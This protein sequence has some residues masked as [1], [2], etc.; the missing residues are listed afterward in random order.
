MKV[1]KCRRGMRGVEEWKCKEMALNN[2]KQASA[3]PKGNTRPFTERKSIKNNERPIVQTN[4]LL[5]TIQ[6]FFWCSVGSFFIVF[7]SL[8]IFYNFL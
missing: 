4:A 6:A 7:N 5:D 2:S 8:Q 3:S 1:K